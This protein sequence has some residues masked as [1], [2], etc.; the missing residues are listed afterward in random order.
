MWGCYEISTRSVFL[1]LMQMCSKQFYQ[2]KDFSIVNDSLLITRRTQQCI[3]EFDTGCSKDYQLQVLNNIFTIL[4]VW[5]TWLDCNNLKSPRIKV[6]EQTLNRQ[7]E[8]GPI[9]WGQIYI[10]PKIFREFYSIKCFWH[11]Q[12]PIKNR[13]QALQSCISLKNEWK[14]H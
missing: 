5:V 3:F 13:K 7:N 8:K 2:F 10:C 14:R 12:N 1:N 6:V 11:F 9:H 4:G